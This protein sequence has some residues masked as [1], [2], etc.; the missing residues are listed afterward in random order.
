MTRAII[1]GTLLVIAEEKSG[2]SIVVPS[3]PGRP[4][5]ASVKAR[6]D[7]VVLVDVNDGEHFLD[8]VRPSDIETAKDVG[9]II[10]KEMALDAGNEEIEY[11]I[12]ADV[13]LSIDHE[14]SGSTPAP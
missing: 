14:E 3:S 10:V 5:F 13:D 2:T 1:E 12:S 8:E 7:G 11:H 4:R 9:A 6:R